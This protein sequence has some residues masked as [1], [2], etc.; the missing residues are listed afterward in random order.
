MKELL[1]IGFLYLASSANAEAQGTLYKVVLNKNRGVPKDTGVP[2]T[3][4]KPLKDLQVSKD[5]SIPNRILS[6]LESHTFSRSFEI[7]SMD[8]KPIILPTLLAILKDKRRIVVFDAN[9]NNNFSDDSVLYQNNPVEAKL[10]ETVREQKVTLTVATNK[11][12]D[13]YFRYTTF[14]PKG[15]NV[16]YKDEKENNFFLM[17]QPFQFFA[18]EITSINRSITL[19]D[20]RYFLKSKGKGLKLY[21]ENE[22]KK[23]YQ[24]GDTVMTPSGSLVF[25]KV[26][27]FYDTLFLES[28]LKKNVIGY[29]EGYL[30]P[31]IS[32]LDIFGNPIQILPQSNKY[33]LLDFWGTWC[34]PCIET[35]PSLKKIKSLFSD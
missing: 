34:V 5:V 14:K 24:I 4:L 33:I 1:I 16:D 21:V 2:F 22:S 31:P 26:S 13:F 20:E 9:L 7:G 15:V 6:N 10:A 25:S 28:F 12:I 8:N 18:G 30:A 32:G 29:N 27:T 3:F 19:V 35:I 17:I 23:G 11:A